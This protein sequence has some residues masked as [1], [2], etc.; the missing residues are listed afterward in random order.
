M[1]VNGTLTDT[2][3]STG[4]RGPG[5]DS[6]VPDG[7]VECAWGHAICR[8]CYATRSNERLRHAVAARGSRETGQGPL[9]ERSAY[10]AHDAYLAE[11]N[12]F[13]QFHGT[14]LVRHGGETLL[15]RGYGAADRAQGRPNMPETIFQLASISKQFTAAATL[16]LQER[17]ALSVGDRI[18]RWLPDCPTTWEPITL[19]QLLTHTSGIGHWEDFPDLSLF[20]PTTWDNL[21]HIFQGLPLKF[22]PGNGWAYSS[23][24]F[25]LLA[26]IVEQV[27]GKPYAA[28]L[29]QEIFQ[30]LGMSS[31]GAGNQSPH[32]DRQ[33]LGYAGAGE[34]PSPSFELD[35]A[36]KGAGD[37]WATTHDLARWNAALG[38][39][40]FL[41][42]AL[43]QAMFA[44]HAHVP[45]DLAGVPGLHY[46]YGWFVGE[47]EGRQWQFHTGGNAG[48]ATVSVL[49]PAHQSM[50]ILLA[51]DES[52]ETWAMS[53][54]IVAEML[55]NAPS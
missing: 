13:A 11:Q 19:H 5:L 53:R 46:G 50:V 45:E 32:P 16:L 21:L 6:G 30:P 44:P 37:V 4:L 54:R 18:Q 23:P 39:P 55:G 1:V 15:D 43:L 52:C 51:N 24:A 2:S 34:E 42:Q 10:L 48:F 49:V 29:Q 3:L 47:V 9:T 22:P 36:G 14:A 41:S 27:T 28:F 35:V 31:T 38:E 40:G 25:V 20:A 17:G 12:Q 8:V 26:H 7:N 33:A